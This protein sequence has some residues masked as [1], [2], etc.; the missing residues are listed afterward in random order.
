MSIRTQAMSLLFALFLPLAAAA[1]TRELPD[2]TDL[3]EKQGPA[4]VNISTSSERQA[5][6]PQI[7][8]LDENDPLYDFFRRFI[9]RQPGPG[10][11][12]QPQLPGPR[13]F[14]QRSLGS[15]FIVSADGYVLTNSHVVNNADEITVR[16]NDKREFK[17]KVI[18]ADTRTDIAV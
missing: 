12:P 13:Q 3:V 8:G 18:G 5:G 4:V 11:Q 6:A 15:G 14:E 9:P 2:F 1:Q 16:L 10:P 17:A 7:P